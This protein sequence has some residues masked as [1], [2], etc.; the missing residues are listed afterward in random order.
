MIEMKTSNMLDDSPSSYHQE[1]YREHVNELRNEYAELV[2]RY[3]AVYQ[4]IP[5][6][7]ELWNED[8]ICYFQVSY[9]GYLVEL[10]D[11]HTMIIK[12]DGDD[13]VVIDYMMESLESAFQRINTMVAG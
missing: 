10:T 7:K 1:L 8:W 11:G 12:P 3:G 5:A 2:T 13:R 4:E 9:K 6:G